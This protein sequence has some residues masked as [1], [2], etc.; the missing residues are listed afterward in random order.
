MFSGQN[1]VIVAGSIATKVV[2]GNEVWAFKKVYYGNR[3]L[4]DK[5]D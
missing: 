5:S 4:Y 1:I 3:R 2:V